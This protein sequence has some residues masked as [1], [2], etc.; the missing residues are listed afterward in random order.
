MNKRILITGVAGFVGSNLA[1]YL[2]D[3]GYD[4]VG[5]D[6]MSSGT[7]NNVDSRV[8][9]HEIDIRDAEIE[10]L[11]DKADS[12]FHLAA[13]TSLTDCLAKPLEAADVNVLGSLNVLE[14]AR[15]AGVSKVVY[16]DTS[17]EYEGIQDFPT[18]EDKVRPIGVYAASKH[19]GAAFCE[20]YRELYQMKITIVRY[21]NVYGPAQ[22]WRRVVPPVMSAFI[23]R[24]LQGE[25][26][27]IYGNGE[28]RRD[29]IYIDDV[30]ALHRLILEDSRSTG[31][32]VFNV[33]TGTN[34]SVNEIYEA[35]ESLLKTGLEPIYKPD[36]P[37][38]AQV[39]LAD[40]SSAQELGWSPRVD[41]RE[42][43]RRSIQ[44]IQ[45]RVLPND[46]RCAA[47]PAV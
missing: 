45:E 39:T 38:E 29:F 43:L 41:L 28:K 4:V 47:I 21:F 10:P 37:G 46:D 35:I 15:K 33:G 2:L 18:P 44:Y 16:A 40:I 25:R 22:D 34:Y 14:A 8:R 31:G 42:G 26:P 19:G 5:I 32:K 6:N 1:R 24:M 3:S 23:I 12:V 17:A 13:K 7:P 30:N 9:C 20:S 11:F 27:I 36:L